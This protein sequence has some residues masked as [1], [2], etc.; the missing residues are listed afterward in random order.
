MK[1]NGK[2]LTAFQANFVKE[3]MGDPVMADARAE[4]QLAKLQGKYGA[5]ILGMIEAAS[6]PFEK[7]NAEFK[8]LEAEDLARS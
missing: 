2:V 8:K 5:D 3:L 4:A 7:R 1:V 6:A